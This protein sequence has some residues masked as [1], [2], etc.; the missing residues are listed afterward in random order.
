MESS[1][2]CLTFCT[3]PCHDY[4]LILIATDHSS[5]LKKAFDHGLKIRLPYSWQSGLVLTTHSW[6]SMHDEGLRFLKDL[7]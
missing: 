5:T 3:E 4:P 1:A 6:L 2:Y 7:I